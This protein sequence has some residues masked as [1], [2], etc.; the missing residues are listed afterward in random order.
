MKIILPGGAG[1]VGQNLVVSLSESGFT[2]IVV[3]DKNQYNL[4][5]LAKVH[6]EVECVHA[7]L[8]VVGDWQKRFSGCDGIVILNA[9]IGAKSP[10][11]F[12]ANN[13]TATEK[14][15]DAIEEYC[16]QARVVHVSSSVVNSVVEDLYVKTKTEQEQIVRRRLPLAVVLRPTLM[17]GWFDRKHLGWLS[18]F[19]KKTPVFPIPGDG[20]YM[21]QPLYVGD[22]C[23][24]IQ[25]CLKNPA[26]EGLYNIS[27]RTRIDYVDLIKSIKTAVDSRT[28]IIRI[29]YKAFQWLLQLYAVFDSNPPFTVSQ[30][31]ALV[32]PDEFEVIDWP[33]IFEVS[34]TQL[35]EALELTFNHP[36]YSEQILQF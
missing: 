11:P 2:E 21:R 9:Q 19:M 27:G 14:V 29:P 34:E 1:L 20:R 23:S 30:L 17:F 5:I 35:D 25:G 26:I 32:A 33:S 13:I 7:D 16:P 22:F 12:I 15:I 24:I 8:A 3:I 4:D 18:R 10:E 28:V 6:P 31:E 36:V